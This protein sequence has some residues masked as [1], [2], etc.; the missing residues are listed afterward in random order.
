MDSLTGGTLSI[1]PTALIIAAGVFFGL[2]SVVAIFVVI[3][4]ANRAEPDP[5]G[6]RP[7]AVYLFGISFFSLFVVL[8]GTF[9]IVLGLVQLIGSHAASFSG[10][11]H[12]VGDAVTRIVVLG[13]IIVAIAAVLLLASLRRVLAFPEI[14]NGQPGPVARVAQSYAASVSFVSV[15]IAAGSL[16]VFFY[17]VFRILA[18]GIFELTGTRVDASRTLLS[19]LYLAFAA[20]AVVGTHARLLPSSGWRRPQSSGTDTGYGGY[21]PPPPPI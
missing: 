17:E 5:S 1:I 13:G 15:I 2:A 6:L 4:V 20:A 12:P 8:F 9:A 19:A 7:L 10:E 3:V 16:V 18:P 11:Q 21:T 14:A